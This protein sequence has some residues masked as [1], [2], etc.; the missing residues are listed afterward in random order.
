MLV[1]TRITVSSYLPSRSSVESSPIFFPSAQ[2]FQ[3]MVEA[4]Q[5]ANP[6]SG[7][8]VF[9]SIKHW[10][11]S[12]PSG[13]TLPLHIAFC[14]LHIHNI[15]HNLLST[16]DDELKAPGTELFSLFGRWGE[17]GAGKIVSGRGGMNPFPPFFA[18][19]F[20]P[21]RRWMGVWEAF[22]LF[23]RGFPPLEESLRRMKTAA[24]M[25][26]LIISILGLPHPKMNQ[27]SR[28]WL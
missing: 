27:P 16:S 4:H 18:L 26:A 7:E 21:S 12:S 15:L 25:L 3:L 17:E 11:K 22:D 20:S 8:G 1:A 24:A 13:R 6:G 28:R 19:G 14:I 9:Q 10:F 2:S 23:R 5:I